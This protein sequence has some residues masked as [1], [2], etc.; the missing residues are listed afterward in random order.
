MYYP[1]Q[2]NTQME[3]RQ[4]DKKG[5]LTGSS[6]QKITGIKKSANGAEA[7]INSESFDAKGKSLGTMQ[8]KARCENGIYYIDMQNYVNPSATESYEDM[9]MSVEGGSLEVPWNM[10]AGDVL[11]NG[12]L[13]MSFSSGG[14][15]VMNMTISITNRKVDAVENITTPAGTFECYK[16]SYDIATKMM[17]N[18]KAKGSEWYAKNVGLVKSESY[19]NDGKLMGSTVLSGIKK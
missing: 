5:G 18:I 6:L 12:D 10:K 4:Y 7:E 17:I 15:T 2:E 16:I 1:E 19:S 14:M 9:E 3:Y 8:L 11:K 13:K